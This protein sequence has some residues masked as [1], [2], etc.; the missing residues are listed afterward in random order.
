MRGLP[1]YVANT[2]QCGQGRCA[3]HVLPEPDGGGRSQLLGRRRHM[4]LT[5]KSSWSGYVAG[6][7]GAMQSS[8]PP[9]PS[10][11]RFS[12]RPCL[13]AGQAAA[14]HLHPIPRTWPPEGDE[15]P[16]PW[17]PTPATPGTPLARDYPAAVTDLRICHG[18]VRST[19]RR[20]QADHDTRPT[21]P[22]VAAVRPRQRGDQRRGRG[23]RRD[24]GECRARRPR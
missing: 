18:G 12:T 20:C 6:P 21:S 14:H 1:Y 13:A 11:A 8:S 16:L 3:G 2:T 9:F 15:A 4:G 17:R 24:I 5:N 23:G 19:R 10:T 22:T 7:R